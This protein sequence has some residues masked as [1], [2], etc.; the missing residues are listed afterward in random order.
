M[1]AVGGADVCAQASRL[2]GVHVTPTV[3]F[4]VSPAEF[5]LVVAADR[6]CRALLRIVSP[7]ALPRSSGMSGC[8]RTVFERCPFDENNVC[9]QVAAMLHAAPV[10]V[11]NLPIWK[12][13]GARRSRPSVK[14]ASSKKR[15][16]ARTLLQLSAKSHHDPHA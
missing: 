7:A 2:V 1:M 15:A 14:N 5:D 12:R 11:K 6:R 9:T 10:P 3:L 8:R 16:A 13:C 4:N